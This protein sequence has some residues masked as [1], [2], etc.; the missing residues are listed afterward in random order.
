MLPNP[1]KPFSSSITQEKQLEPAL[2]MG[3]A[4][5]DDFENIILYN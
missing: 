1:S 2:K 3:Q 4:D 5:S